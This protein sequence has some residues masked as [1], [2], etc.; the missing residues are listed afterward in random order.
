MEHRIPLPW[1]L[2]ALVLALL[3]VAPAAAEDEETYEGEVAESAELFDEAEALREHGKVDE[4]ATKY[5]EA[6]DAN[7]QNYRAWV[8][9]QEAALAAGD[10]V[11]TMVEDLD[12]FIEDYP[13]L[14]GLKLHKLRLTQDAEER[15]ASLAPML[16]A[17][18]GNG[19]VLLEHGRALLATGKAQQAIDPL[20]KAAAVAPAERTDVMLLLARAEYEAGKTKEARTRLE[21]LLAAKPQ[22]FEGSLTL[23][24]FDLR[25]LDNE[26][27]LKRAVGVLEM[28]PG[29]IAAVLLKSESES[30]AGK[31][32]E[33]LATLTVA[34]REYPTHADI[35]IAYANL[36]VQ[37]DTDKSF[38]S[39]EVVY[40]S[41]IDADEENLRALYGLGWLYELQEKYEQSEAQYA[42]VASIDPS[43]HMAINSLGYVMFKQGRISDAQVQ[44]KKA[45]DLKAD[46]VTAQLNL[47]ATYDAQA[48]YS[49]GIKVYE[50][51]LSTEGMEKNFRALVNCAFD[52]ESLGTFP[53]ALRYLLEAHD[54]APKDAQL[55]TWIADNHYFQKKWKDALRWYQK[56]IELDEK[57]FFAWRG[58]GYTLSQMKRWEDAVKALE[59]SSTLDPEDLDVLIAIAD[60][61]M[62]ETEDLEKAL[63]YYLEYVQRGGDDPA[64]RDI[65]PEIQKKLAK[66]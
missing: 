1:A 58:M 34:R 38:Q 62:Y 41:V 39:A 42:E 5:W 4:A 45:M 48:K 49:E 66:K 44:F 16:K 28:R 61:S 40:K 22:F 46:F 31:A 53:K 35:G 3:L 30:R 36:L 24:R 27:A 9:Y 64:V 52:Y 2:V 57:S 29:H 13:Q 60:I 25:E 17:H 43:N 33:A 15:L 50:K 63:K 20:T 47:G 54:L 14:I 55:T 12:A 56:A 51:I 11:E 21:T 18:K 8:R 19:D 7:L 6:V 26:N 59:K 32:E 23:G 65:I 10:K 37:E